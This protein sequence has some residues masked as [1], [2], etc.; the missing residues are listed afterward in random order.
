MVVVT[1]QAH[2][3]EM[4]ME[5][6]VGWSASAI[7]FRPVTTPPDPNPLLVPLSHSIYYCF[8][9]IDFLFASAASTA[10]LG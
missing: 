8:N 7:W 2:A 1:L 5:E 6:R 10:G 3:F 9:C 4:Q